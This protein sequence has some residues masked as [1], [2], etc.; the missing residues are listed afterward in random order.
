M[1]TAQGF[2]EKERTALSQFKKRIEDVDLENKDLLEDRRLINWLR[3]RDLRLDDAEAMFRKVLYISNVHVSNFWGAGIDTILKSN[4]IPEELKKIIPIQIGGVDKD[5]CPIQVI[6]TG[7]FEVKKVIQ[8]F[9][10]RIVLDTF[11]LYLEYMYTECISKSTDKNE[12]KKF[13][14]IIDLEGLRYKD[15]LSSD[16]LDVLIT[17]M[18][19]VEAN[20]PEFLKKA[21]IP[22]A[23]SIFT[24]LW[25]LLKPFLS[26]KTISN[27]GIFDS[28]LENLKNSLFEQI[29]AN[30]LPIKYG[31]TVFSKRI[32]QLNHHSSTVAEFHNG[33]EETIISAGD[34]FEIPFEVENPMTLLSWSFKTKNYDIGVSVVSVSKQLV[35]GAFAETE[36]VEYKRYN[37]QKYVQAGSVACGTGHFILRFDNTYSKL[38]AKTLLYYVEMTK[39]TEDGNR[40][41]DDIVRNIES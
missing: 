6:Y 40:N 22:N 3:A 19:D 16:V 12:L 39:M 27:V 25:N 7:G 15:C 2:T 20:Y 32:P 31:G 4:N 36:I 28:N 37:A 38:R 18:K 34:V 21:Y 9:G 33:F 29:A 5:G 8:K 41:E 24:V 23:P 17:A 10:K 35:H 1:P 13:I 14:N 30:Q 11:N 26:Q